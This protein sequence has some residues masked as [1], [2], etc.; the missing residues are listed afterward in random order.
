MRFD[1]IKI[2][3]MTHPQDFSRLYLCQLAVNG[4]PCV[5][6]YSHEIQRRELGEQAWLESLK[7]NAAGLLAEH[8]PAPALT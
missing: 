3:E 6:F 4:I 7:E 2:K 8:G 1:I 5:P